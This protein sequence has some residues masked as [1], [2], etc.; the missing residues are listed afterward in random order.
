MKNSEVV[1][2]LLETQTQLEYYTGKQNHSQDMRLMGV[3][4][5]H[6]MI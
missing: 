6:L 4:M 3:F 2:F 5:I 1:K